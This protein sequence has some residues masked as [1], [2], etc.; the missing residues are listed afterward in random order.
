MPKTADRATTTAGGTEGKESE[1][2]RIIAFVKDLP[3]TGSHYF[4][5]KKT[6]MSICATR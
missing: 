5:G 6:N 4:L 2:V 3:A 1:V